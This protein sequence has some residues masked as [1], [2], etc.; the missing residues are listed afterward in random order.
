MIPRCFPNGSWRRSR[1]ISAG[2]TSGAC[3]TETVYR[4]VDD[5]ETVKAAFQTHPDVS[6]VWILLATD[7]AA[8]GLDLQNFCSRLIH[9]EIPWN[10]LVR[11][12]ESSLS[13]I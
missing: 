4:T 6:L 12:N 2:K 10:S 8:E 13:G 1:R 9:Y 3:V 11:Q 5:R 7:A